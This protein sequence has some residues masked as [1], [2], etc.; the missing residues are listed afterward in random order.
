MNG[1]VFRETVRQSGRTVA[2]LSAGA[3]LFTYLVLFSSKSFLSEGSGFSG[4]FSDPPKAIQA[5]LGGSVNLLEPSGWVAAA[6][7]HPIMY[8]LLTSA[9]VGI[10]AGSV[11]TEVERGTID[12][13]LGRPVGRRPY[14]LAKAA[15]AVAAVTLVEAG[16]LA[17]TLAARLTIDRLDEV[18]AVKI[19]GAFVSSWLLFTAIALVAVLVSARSSLRGRAL[20]LAVG[21]VVGSFFLNFIALLVNGLA[22]LRFASVFHYYA[23]TRILSGTVPG[24]DLAVLAAVGVAALGVATWWFGRRD[25]SR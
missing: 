18:G 19:V 1:R 4:F 10:A 12:L 24:M 2:I 20:G 7:T 14:L 5:F 8:A 16:A 15:A 25:L 17:G 13:V 23:P 11:A 22:P 3:G 9:G 21:F 6:L